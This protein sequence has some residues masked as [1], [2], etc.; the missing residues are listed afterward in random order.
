MYTMRRSFITILL[1]GVVGLSP[2]FAF[3]NSTADLRA[4]IEELMRQALAIREQIRQMAFAQPVQ[5]TF[6]LAGQKQVALQVGH[7][8][9]ENVP[10][11]LRALD[12]HRQAAGG[13]KMEWEINLVIVQ[14]TA[15][16]LEAQGIGVTIL[17][18]I[19]PSIYKAD[20]FVA[21]HA[22]QN[23]S[24]PFASGFKVAASAF[25]QSGKAE[26]LAQLLEQEYIKITGL[27]QETYIPS[28]MPYYYA[29]NS[30]KFLYAIHPQTPA[31]II[32]T[33]YLSNPRDRA[34]ILTNPDM[35]AEGI[36]NAILEF[37]KE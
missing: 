12:P 24:L 32:E 15:K 26:R 30:S 19:L 7:W 27:W 2:S 17:S 25:D 4:Q 14:K 18:S 13:G 6:T 28:S 3:A 8:K 5:A 37:L 22:D 29:F 21:I 23:P 16:I 10:W 11:E 9:M 1:V 36:A 35:A 34:I 33:G 31:A 20:V